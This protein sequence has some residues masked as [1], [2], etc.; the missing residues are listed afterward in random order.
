MKRVMLMTKE[1]EK[2]FAETG[3]QEKKGWD[4]K[5]I[6]KYFHPMSNYTM[7]VTE[8]NP[9][10]RTLF[11]YTILQH[12]EWGYTSLDELETSLA[13][14]L[15]VERDLHWDQKTVREA[16]KEIGKEVPYEL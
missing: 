1:L 15:P 13:R 9:R 6:C 4:A 7:F 10:D 16:L 5:V 8:Y 12:D 3:S 2:Q 14:G 11:G